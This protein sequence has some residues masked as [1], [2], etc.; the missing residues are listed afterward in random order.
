MT[1]LRLR[2]VLSPKSKATPILILS[3][4][5]AS[6]NSNS[7]PMILAER[8]AICS[9]VPP[10]VCQFNPNFQA[11]PLLDRIPCDTAGLSSSSAASPSSYILR[12][13]LPDPTRS[14]D[15][16]TCACLLASA[17]LMD[18]TKGESVAV[19]RPYT[20]I[21]TNNQV[22]CFDLLIKDYG[23]NG[24]LSKYMCED[25]PIGGTVR[26]VAYSRVIFLVR[27][28]YFSSHFLFC[29]ISSTG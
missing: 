8:P 5:M 28:P 10:G 3:S 11:V 18:N 21:S 15:L 29:S 25:L 16:T 13:G 23:E 22:G 24:W 19:T 20:P 2:R 7:Y 17:E 14:M 27:T 12:F 26:E 6:S 4:T 1:M 9:L